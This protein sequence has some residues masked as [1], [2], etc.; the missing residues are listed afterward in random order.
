MQSSEYFYAV[1]GIFILNTA[2]NIFFSPL[3]KIPGPTIAALSSLYIKYFSLTSQRALKVHELHQKY[4]LTL[5]Y[6]LQ[7]G[8]I[9]RISP[10]AI[11][12][13]QLS[14]VKEIYSISNPFEKDTW[15]ERFNYS[16]GEF[17]IFNMC[18]TARH[19]I[20]RRILAHGFSQ[21]HLDSLE[22]IVRS[23]VTIAVG[24]M[25]RDLV[26]RKTAT[27]VMK[28]WMFMA[29]DVIATLCFGESFH[30]LEKE[31][32]N[33][34]IRDLLDISSLALVF[35]EIPLP[36]KVLDI[37]GKMLPESKIKRIL[38][39]QQR[40]IEHGKK[41]ILQSPEMTI[42]APDKTKKFTIL[43]KMFE[44]DP[45]TGEKLTMNNIQSEAGHM[46]AAGTDTT[47]VTMTYLIWEV[48]KN[49]KV[50]EKL[51]GELSV[52]PSD[53]TD[54]DLRN[55]PYLKNVILETL[56]LHS[57]VQSGLPR[58][59]PQG[60]RNFGGYDVPE[61]VTVSVQAYTLHRNESIFPDPYKFKP[62]RWEN[63]TPEMQAAFFAFGGG[64]RVCL[65]IHL[66][67]MELRLATATFFTQCGNV[68][69]A[70]TVNDK[71]MEF[72][73]NFLIMPKGRKCE[74]VA[75]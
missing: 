65:G 36:M 26:E 57:V 49:P 25:R 44:V 70:D 13:S 73:D 1:L 24:K 72:D 59:V 55:L 11:S 56:R 51:M 61:G 14:A 20:R 42:N 38:N 66:A 34:Y 46:L 17:G 12:V 47:S 30:M 35:A 52:L 33:E 21:T 43:A 39:Y 15:Y 28:W 62:S 9:V 53:I 22:P 63:P 48:L 27:D 41:A 2:Y 31:E 10:S 23:K 69:L 6:K 3:R 19:R 4:G 32:K 7:K 60:G 74:V 54:V 75:C 5:S 16:G 68:R 37:L 45:K 8:P 40:Q 29:T 18:D 64:N 58:L 67:N 50:H 71:D